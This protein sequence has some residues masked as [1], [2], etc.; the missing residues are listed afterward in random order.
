MDV[1]AVL[2]VVAASIAQAFMLVSFVVWVAGLMNA[3][4]YGL[5]PRA[6]IPVCAAILTAIGYLFI[7]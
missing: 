5:M 1:V 4:S 3:V 2:L 6:T 7:R